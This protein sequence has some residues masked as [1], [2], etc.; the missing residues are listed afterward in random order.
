MVWTLFLQVMV[1]TGDAVTYIPESSTN[2]L[3][4]DEAPYFVKRIDSD[5]I[6]SLTVNRMW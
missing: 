3:N 5:T 2:T 6:N 4:I 1:W